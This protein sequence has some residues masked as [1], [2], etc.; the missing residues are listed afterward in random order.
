[1]YQFLVA[2][3]IG[4]FMSLSDLTYA[5]WQEGLGVLLVLE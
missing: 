5:N 2:G 4:M 1:M 3:Y